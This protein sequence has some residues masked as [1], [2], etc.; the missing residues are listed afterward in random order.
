M[1]IRP[2]DVHGLA[3]TGQMQLTNIAFPRDTYDWL[4]AR[5]FPRP[6]ALGR[7]SW[8]RQS[9]AWTDPCSPASPAPPKSCLPPRARGWPLSDSCSTCAM[10]WPNRP[11]PACPRRPRLVPPG[12]PA[13]PPARTFSRRRAGLHPTDR[14]Q[15][16]AC[17][18]RD[19]PPA[20]R[21]PL[22]FCQPHPPAARR[23]PTGPERGPDHGHC[24]GLR[25][26]KP[27]SLLPSDSAANSGSRPMSIAGVIARIGK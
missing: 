15:P 8:S 22:G 5:Y 6:L 10:L 3:T 9:A 26:R 23:P 12:L 27:E 20:R 18:P 11:S 17:G 24:P 14:P 7:R 4:Q 25:H 21:N 19:P 1:F 2:G 13:D 16:R